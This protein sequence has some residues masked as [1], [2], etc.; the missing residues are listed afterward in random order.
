L[1]GS[2]WTN[3]LQYQPQ[4]SKYCDWNKLNDSDWKILE[5]YTPL[6]LDNTEFQNLNNNE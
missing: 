2:D 4:F 3:L 6:L 1:S 5:K